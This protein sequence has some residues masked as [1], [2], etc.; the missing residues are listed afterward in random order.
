MYASPDLINTLWD[1]LLSSGKVEPCGLGCRDTLR[2]EVGLPLYGNELG[3]DISPL[4]AGLGVFVKL[5]K[6]VCHEYAGCTCTDN[7]YVIILSHNYFLSNQNPI[8]F[9]P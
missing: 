6:F 1:K 2:F 4:E 5:D 7:N 9:Y 8:C 3:D